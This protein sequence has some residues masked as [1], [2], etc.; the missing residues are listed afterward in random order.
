MTQFLQSQAK[1]FGIHL[2]GSLNW[3]RTDTK[4]DWL[5]DP[6]EIKEIV[7]KKANQIGIIQRYK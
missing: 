6:P 2:D 3:K 7:H 5:E 1:Y 4:L